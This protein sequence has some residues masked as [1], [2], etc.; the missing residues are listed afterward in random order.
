M[1][2]L[3]I[4]LIALATSF[5]L[6]SKK[7]RD[8]QNWKATVTPLASIIGSGFLVIVPLLGHSFG[9]YAPV[10]I[11][12]II[13]VAYAVGSSIRFNIRYSEHLIEENHTSVLARIDKLSSL[14]LGIA[15]I[16][17]VAFYLRLLASFA[18]HAF[19]IEHDFYAK[20]LTSLI[21]LSIGIGGWVKGLDVLEKLEEYSV[22]IKLAIISS[23]LFA[24]AVHDISHSSLSI[25]SQLVP[26]NFDSINAFR[27]LAGALIVVQGFETSRY[28]GETYSP[29]TRIKTMKY[30]QVV[31]GIIYIIFVTLTVPTF[32]HLGSTI[33]DT[34][35]IDLSKLVAGVLPVMLIIAAIMSQFSA[36][37]ADTIGAGGLIA[38]NSEKKLKSKD[39][40][41]LVTL[42]G[43]VLVWF[44]DIFEII[45]LASRAFAF[46]Y[47]LQCSV[48]VLTSRK[49]NHKSN[50]NKNI[51]TFYFIFLSALL[52][53]ITI[54]ALPAD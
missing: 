11:T 16:I 28:L 26:M 32:P 4:I 29:E 50:L 2:N 20:L 17:S 7:I 45:S 21:L 5:I 24:W 3:F 43:I 47:F 12:L 14:T 51:V 35:I 37:V 30:A 34:A 41:A 36:A 42:L 22:S 46:Y 18:L 9:S 52:L 6:L 10:A 38:Q 15:Y 49:I 8:N 23:L 40:Y 19:D 25:F 54:F 1:L 31:A 33:N 39:G 27:I 13:V 48:S 44:A 53:A